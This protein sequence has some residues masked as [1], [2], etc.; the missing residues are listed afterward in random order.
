MWFESSNYLVILEVEDENQLKLL[1]NKSE[2]I[3]IKCSVFKEPDLNNQITAVAFEPGDLS[4]R[5]LRN[6]KLAMSL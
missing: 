1:I 5:L 2:E 4:R 6:I 3:C